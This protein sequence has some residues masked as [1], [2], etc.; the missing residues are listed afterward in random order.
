MRRNLVD[1]RIRKRALDGER[2]SSAKRQRPQRVK[3]GR[4]RIERPPKRGRP[5]A[6]ARR[7]LGRL[8]GKH[9]DIGLAPAGCGVAES[10]EAKR[11]HHPG[12][13]F[14][15]GAVDALENETLGMFPGVWVALNVS[16]TGEALKWP[17]ESVSVPVRVTPIKSG[18]FALVT[19]D[20]TV[21]SVSTNVSAPG[22]GAIGHDRMTSAPSGPG[23]DP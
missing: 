9:G 5:I 17:S 18:S 4:Q 15:N 20:V 19:I 10:A 8:R 13:G 2:P 21:V 12:R 1:D 11:H 14:R 23:P 22:A 3:R 7:K 16:S 6:I